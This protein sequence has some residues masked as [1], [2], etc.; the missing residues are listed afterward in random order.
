VEA[1]VSE[2]VF[3]T[4]GENP[5][6]YTPQVTELRGRRSPI[7]IRTLCVEAETEAPTPHLSLPSPPKQ[8]KVF[9]SFFKKKRFLPT[10]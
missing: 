8:T 6:G 9:V 7:Q 5:P 3:T 10:S 1:V 2:D 4:A